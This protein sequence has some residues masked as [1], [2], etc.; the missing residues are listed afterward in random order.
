[1]SLWGAELGLSTWGE[2]VALTRAAMADPSTRLGAKVVGWDYPATMPQLLQIVA[3]FGKQAAKVLP[4]DPDAGDRP[5]EA[6]I[7]AA[8]AELEESIIIIA[9]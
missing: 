9:D 3:N 8:A 5:A 4:F 7:A 6:E 1:M 2:I